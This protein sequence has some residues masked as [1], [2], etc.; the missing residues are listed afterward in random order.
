M[1]VALEPGETK[2]AT[3]SLNMRALA[4]FDEQQNAWVAE[5]GAFEILIGASSDD[6]RGQAQFKLNETWR[7][8][9]IQ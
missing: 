7:E 6:I 1:K 5:K 8:P 2:V 9:V 4:Y 3:F